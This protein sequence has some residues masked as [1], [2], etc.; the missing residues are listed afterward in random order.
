MQTQK[1]EFAML[2][3]PAEAANEELPP[4]DRVKAPSGW[5]PYEIWRT[6]IKA[7]YEARLDDRS[8]D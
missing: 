5:D 4:I 3:H 7:A 2:A 1:N 6:R 8:R